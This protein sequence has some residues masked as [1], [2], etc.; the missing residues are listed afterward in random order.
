[1][2]AG[3]PPVIVAL[4]APSVPWKHVAL[5]ATLAML[6]AGGDV[7]TKLDNVEVQALASVT[8]TEYVPG[9]RLKV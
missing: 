3:E 8:T 7:T 1:M 5:V 6:I 2:N 4:I 9:A